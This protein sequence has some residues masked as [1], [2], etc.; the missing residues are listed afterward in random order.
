MNFVNKYQNKFFVN[1]FMLLGV[2][3]RRLGDVFPPS[4]VL[5]VVFSEFS[6]FCFCLARDKHRERERERETDR[7]T[8]RQTET[9]REG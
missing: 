6:A 9:Q 7:Q 5:F 2:S 8:D 4:F 3:H 1:K